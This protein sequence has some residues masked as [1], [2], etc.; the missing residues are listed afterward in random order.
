M[1]RGIC[2]LLF[3]L[4]HSLSQI[5]PHSRFFHERLTMG[6][7]FGTVID[8]LTAAKLTVQEQPANPFLKKDAATFTV[9]Y[10]DTLFGKQVGVSLHFSKEDSV[11][12]EIAVIFLGVDPKTGKVQADLDQ[13]I[14]VLWDSLSTHWGPPS[15]DKS[16]PF[17]AKVREWLFSSAEIQMLR[18]RTGTSTL[19]VTYRGRK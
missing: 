7:D 14:D 2:L 10:L 5:V 4:Q 19:A 16:V 6:S 8:K 9:F 3:L 1:Y 15:K 18:L 17:V 11:L 12:S 13:S